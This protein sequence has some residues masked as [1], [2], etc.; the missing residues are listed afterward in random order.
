M[1]RMHVRERERERER[2]MLGGT[3]S[4]NSNENI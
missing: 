3:R 2:E 4:E 1:A